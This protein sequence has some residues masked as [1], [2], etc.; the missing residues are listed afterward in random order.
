MTILTSI[1]LVAA[2]IGVA[3]AIAYNVQKGTK[4]LEEMRSNYYENEEVQ[5]VVELSKEL[6]NRDLRPVVAKKAPK[7]DK[8]TELV[9]SMKKVTDAHDTLIEEINRISPETT[10]VTVEATVEAPKKKK[11]HRY[12][13]KPKTQTPTT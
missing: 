1:I 11:G 9:E 6:Y 2:I 3:A 7:K 12:N 4:T 5:E 10:T 13:R 8:V